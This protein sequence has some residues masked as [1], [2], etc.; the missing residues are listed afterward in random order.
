MMHTKEA[1]AEIDEKI[2]EM[3]RV[4]DQL[5]S[6]RKRMIDENNKVKL[7]IHQIR[8]IRANRLAIEEKSE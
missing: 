5:K 4:L 8:K 7:A 3:T 6:Q 1:I 2:R